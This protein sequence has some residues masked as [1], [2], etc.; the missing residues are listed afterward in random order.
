MLTLTAILLCT[1]NS[2]KANNSTSYIPY[3][4][5]LVNNLMNNYNPIVPPWNPPGNNFTLMVQLE[6]FG[7]TSVDEIGSTFS[8]KAAL[9]QWWNDTRLQWDPASYGNI[10]KIWLPSDP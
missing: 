9:R 5:N 1:L 3:E 4:S 10:T 7:V 6:I 8:F 2:V